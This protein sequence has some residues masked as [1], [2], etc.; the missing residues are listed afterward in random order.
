MRGRSGMVEKNKAAENSAACCT[1]NASLAQI[2][3]SHRRIG[4]LVATGAT[5]ALALCFVRFG[6]DVLGGLAL[7]DW[8]D[9]GFLPISD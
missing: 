8:L 3:R 4:F 1:E 5:T 9:H 7:E 2:G 6:F